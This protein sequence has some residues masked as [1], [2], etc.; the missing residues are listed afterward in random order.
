MYR[1]DDPSAA[2]SLPAPEAA[3]TGGY[4]TE[5]N[6]GSGVPATLVR[7]SWL[8]MIQE[9]LV[10]VIAAAGLTPSKTTYNQ[11]LNAI[12]ALIPS[13]FAYSKANPGW[14]KLPNGL[15]VQWF[16]NITT[17]CNSSGLATFNLR[18]PTSFASMVLGSSFYPVNEAQSAV[19]GQTLIGSLPPTL[20][21]MS[22]NLAGAPPSSLVALSGFVCGF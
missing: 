22:I 14:V 20:T 6:P 19:A 12:N 15:I 17:T 3:G 1:I 11:L 13:A 16:R 4:W 18:F 5:G 10:N 2:T 8:N 7:A 9:E 21:D